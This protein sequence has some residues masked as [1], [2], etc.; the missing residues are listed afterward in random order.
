MARH[1][2]EWKTDQY[3]GQGTSTYANGDRYVGQIRD[4]EYHGQGTMIFNGYLVCS[5]GFNVV[6]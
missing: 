5:K 3:N 4:D 6:L 2:G 1:L